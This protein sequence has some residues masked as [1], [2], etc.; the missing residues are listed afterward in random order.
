[1]HQSHANPGTGL[2][3]LIV[4]AGPKAGALEV[5]GLWVHPPGSPGCPG[6]SI[7]GLTAYPQASL[8]GCSTNQ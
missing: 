5:G 7:S 8:C 4:R 1:M 6:L 2:G 3:Q